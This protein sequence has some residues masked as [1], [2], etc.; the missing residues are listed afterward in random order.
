MILFF[1]IT[2]ACAV[3]FVHP[4]VTYPASLRLLRPWPVPRPSEPRPSAT[5][6]FCAYNESASV[7]DKV[8][9]LRAIRAVAPEVQFKCYVDLSSDGTLELLQA[10]ADIL[11]VHAATERTGKALGMRRL[12]AAT[13]TDVMIFTDANV[14]VEPASVPRML[15]Y[16]RDPTVGGVCGTLVYLNPGESE[17]ASVNSAYWRLEESIKKGETRSGSTMGA[18]GSIFATRRALY[19]EVPAHLLDDFIVSMSVVFAGRRLISVPDVVAYE[20]SAASSGDEFR[21]KRRIAARAY[22]SH[23]YLAPRL[24]RMRAVD[25]YKYVSHR[26]VRWYGGA[27]VAVGWVSFIL[28]VYGVAEP[29]AAGVTALATVGVA[30]AIL[31][32]RRGAV[33]RVA[34]M[35]RA[36]YATL[37]GVI[38]AWRGKRYQTWQPPQ[39]R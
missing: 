5:L 36:I 16:F 2:G 24:R 10:H 25:Q 4:Y 29:A 14:M 6:V 32:V 3:M 39:T 21:R 27:L 1:A 18:D 28:G 37:L 15:D 7:A 26:V 11:D 20:K 34:E 30:A 35:A 12:A 31:K 33:G 17:T 13:T 23:R 9:N 19:P 8:A 38:D 22:A